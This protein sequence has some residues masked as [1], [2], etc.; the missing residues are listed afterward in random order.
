MKLKDPLNPQYTT[1]V[2]DPNK[3][4]YIT[5]ED[6]LNPFSD[7]P[8][9][10]LKDT[11]NWYNHDGYMYIE[12]Q[13]GTIK[14]GTT[15]DDPISSQLQDPQYPN[16]RKL[17]PGESWVI[18][19]PMYCDFRRDPSTSD[20][21]INLVDPDSQFETHCTQYWCSDAFCTDNCSSDGKNTCIKG[22][23]K[24]YNECM[25]SCKDPACKKKC[26][27][28]YTNAMDICDKRSKRPTEC[29]Q[30]ACNNVVPCVAN[31][32]EMARCKDIWTNPADINTHCNYCGAT[33]MQQLL[34]VK[35]YNEIKKNP[36]NASVAKKQYN[37][38]IKQLSPTMNGD[39]I[40]YGTG[41]GS[42][43]HKRLCGGLGGWVAEASD[44]PLI[45]I[46]I[47][48]DSTFRFEFNLN[49]GDPTNISQIDITQDKALD[50]VTNGSIGTWYNLSGV[51]GINSEI[52]M[53]YD[54][55]KAKDIDTAW[56]CCIDKTV[57]GTC[58]NPDSDMIK[59]CNESAND[60]SSKGFKWYTHDQINPKWENSIGIMIRVVHLLKLD[61]SLSIENL[62]KIILTK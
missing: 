32:E 44:N 9:P 47:P 39:A 45:D 40:D 28:A 59:D 37:H 46:N 42:Q 62:L 57:Y 6:L 26:S 52:E 56:P 34:G 36:K 20:G 1:T 14:S 58:R 43:P 10:Y 18:I 60:I 23:V 49:G 15:S 24:T 21:T 11:C 33:Y 51:D 13:D 61:V 53:N 3:I 5:N 17:A 41:R 50:I 29:C 55:C 16:K 7:S 8:E 31:S 19:P 4:T 25:L 30:Q 54:K 2:T 48:S 22:A 38:A 35:Y 27:D 12:K